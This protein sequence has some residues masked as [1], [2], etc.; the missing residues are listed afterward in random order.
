MP[1]KQKAGYYWYYYK[2]IY[3]LIA[4]AVIIAILIGI[5]LHR[6]MSRNIIIHLIT[7]NADSYNINEG[8]YFDRFLIAYGYPK[9]AELEIESNIE[10][11]LGSE[12]DGNL[13]S[14][15]VQLLAARFSTGDVDVFISDEELYRAECERNGLLDLRE[16]LPEEMLSDLSE[17]LWYADDPDTGESKPYGICLSEFRICGEEYIYDPDIVPVAGVA[18]QYGVEAG[19]IIKLLAYLSDQPNP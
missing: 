13:S 8:D 6:Q 18:S 14:S 3:L 15:G 1:P 10:V 9:D 16:I 11:H 7:V 5:S 4:G 19:D 17:Q 2:W 12:N